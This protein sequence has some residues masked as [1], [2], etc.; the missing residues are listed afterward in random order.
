MKLGVSKGVG[1]ERERGVQRRRRLQRGREG[2]DETPDALPAG[3]EGG[4]GV[5]LT[6]DG[7]QKPSFSQVKKCS[8]HPFKISALDQTPPRISALII[9][10]GCE[11]HSDRYA[12]CVSCD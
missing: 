9:A 12:S 5:R 4:L 1:I 10:V 3:G 7:N 2:A 6:P 8:V 11:R